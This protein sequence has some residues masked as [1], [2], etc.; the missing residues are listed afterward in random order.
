MRLTP[1]MK[2]FALKAKI[3]NT[4]LAATLD[5][6]MLPFDVGVAPPLP[7]HFMLSGSLWVMFGP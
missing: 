7:G 1:Q 2:N 3:S 5:M 6:A 4:I